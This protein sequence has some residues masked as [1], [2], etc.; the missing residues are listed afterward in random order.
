MGAHRVFH[1]A[2]APLSPDP[3]ISGKARRPIGS[4]R[5]TRLPPIRSRLTGLLS[6]RNTA[7]HRC[8]FWPGHRALPLCPAPAYKSPGRPRY[9]SHPFQEVSD[10]NKRGHP[11]WVAPYR[12]QLH[13]SLRWHYPHQVGGSKRLASSQP[14][15]AS[16]PVFAAIIPLSPSTVKRGPGIRAVAFPPALKYP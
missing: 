8:I 7:S 15:A 16:S 1:A 10:Y 13:G 9:P 11:N 4:K 5:A 12:M 14:A 3:P 2:I 6:R